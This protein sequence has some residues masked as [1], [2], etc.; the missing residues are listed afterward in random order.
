MTAPD[1]AALV[2]DVPHEDRC[3]SHSQR[4][5]RFPHDPEPCDCDRDAR[6]ARGIEAVRESDRG[7][8]CKYL[9][10]GVFECE[11]GFRLT[12]ENGP[13]FAHVDAAAARAFEEAV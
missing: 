6:I 4:P 13:F 11:C 3:A 1:F 12:T 5:G 2:V 9:G 8:V 10:G 7:H